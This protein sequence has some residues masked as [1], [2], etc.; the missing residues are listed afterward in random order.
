MR[1][2]RQPLSITGLFYAGKPAAFPEYF[3]MRLYIFFIKSHSK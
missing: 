1:S 2:E 3:V